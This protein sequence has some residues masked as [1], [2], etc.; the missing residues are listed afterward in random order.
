MSL[1][2]STTT[3]EA[4]QPAAAAPA[5][6]RWAPLRP[7]V[8]RLHF[9]AGVFVAPFLLVAAVTG[10]AVRRCLPGREDRLPGPDDRRRR[11]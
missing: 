9:Y 10:L 2:P 1:A 11:R 6:S 5:P 7:L 3:D 4:P 8:L